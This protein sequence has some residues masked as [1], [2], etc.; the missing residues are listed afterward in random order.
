[1]RPFPVRDLMT[2]GMPPG[3]ESLIHPY[4]GHVNEFRPIGDEKEPG[5]T[6]VLECEKGPVFVKAEPN[7][8]WRRESLL[9]EK[10]V[11]PLAGPLSARLLWDAED[12]EWI[13]LGFEVLD[14]RP[15][16]FSPGSADLPVV[17]ELVDEIG[18]VRPPQ[19]ARDWTETRWDRF[20]SDQSE[21]EL[22]RGDALLH[23][24]LHQENLII[25]AC[26]AWVVDWG[27]PTRGAGFIDPAQIVVQLVAAGLSPVA[28]ESWGA[29]C[30]AWREANP[31]GIDAFAGA[32][33]RMWREMADRR[34]DRQGRRTFAEAAEA[35]ARHRGVTVEPVR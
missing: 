9:R 29:G 18:A 7:H 14:G 3:V 17:R 12:G 25:G 15:A 26:R 2:D 19:A 6:A 16:D 24:D 5:L 10:L 35:W 22:L 31:E 4:T 32:T 11:T 33:V 23:A 1:M 27:W 30:A 8:G 34:P 20:L 28:A 21:A 13:A